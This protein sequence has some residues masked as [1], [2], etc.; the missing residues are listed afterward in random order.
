[1]NATAFDQV[2]GG[3]ARARTEEKIDSL[4]VAKPT[5]SL[6]A[7]LNPFAGRPFSLETLFGQLIATDV[8]SMTGISENWLGTA[9]S[10]GDAVSAI[11]QALSLLASSSETPAIQRA[12]SHLSSVEIAGTAYSAR[13]GILASHTADLVLVTESNSLQTASALAVMRASGSPG[14]A[15]A[16]EETFLETFSPKL[17]A[18]L[19]PVTP[20]FTQL[21]LP[22]D[23][24]SGGGSGVTAP[25]V[26]AGRAFESIPLPKV[27]Q[28]AFADAGYG[29][30][31]RA[32]TPAEVISQVGRP[33]PD[34]LQSIAAGATPTQAASAAAPS[35]P[36]LPAGAGASLPGSLSAPVGGAMTGG[37][38]GLAVA[39][40]GN[41]GRAGGGPEGAASGFGGVPFAGA[42]AGTGAG[43]GG[44]RGTGGLGRMGAGGFGTGGFGAGAGAGGLGAGSGSGAGGL[45]AGAGAGAGGLG[46]GVGAGPGAGAGVGAGG[47]GS[48]TFIGG[49]GNQA[50]RG[51][52]AGVPGAYGGGA[53]RGRKGKKG[54]VQAVTSAVEREGNLKA[55]LGEAPEVVPGVIGAWVREPRR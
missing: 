16:F 50:A 52:A 51:G 53:N 18:E 48:N 33:N 49:Q 42:G 10:V 23:S 12:M 27:M 31:A 5:T 35:L 39:P 24:P 47:A 15:K 38:P 4:T 17:T 2:D 21:L 8:G 43:A 20:S 32:T 6:F 7:A 26:Q 11:P 28:D 44:A 19:V 14:L 3:A 37:G 54:R 34:M 1:M 45:G 29:E 55:L 41:P 46:P 40:M 25:D 36:P 22:L 13:A 9:T 30:L